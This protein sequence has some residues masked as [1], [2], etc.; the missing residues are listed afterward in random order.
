MGWRYVCNNCKTDKDEDIDYIGNDIYKCN[1]CGSEK[2]RQ[3][4]IPHPYEYRRAQ[5][6]ATGNRWSIEN[7]NATH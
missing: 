5:V 3:I 4:Y 2:I 7:F 1:K 6:Y